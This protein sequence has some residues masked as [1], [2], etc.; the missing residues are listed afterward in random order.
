MRRASIT[1]QLLHSILLACI[2]LPRQSR[3]QNCTFC[4]SGITDPSVVL[5]GG[6]QTCADLKN[7]SS[8]LTSD[9]GELCKE[10]QGEELT[11]CPDFI[12]DLPT[13]PATGSPA[14]SSVVVRTASPSVATLASISPTLVQNTTTA[15]STLPLNTSAPSTLSPNTTAPTLSS[16]TSAPSLSPTNQ[17]ITLSP[18]L[19]PTLPPIGTAIISGFAFYD[20]NNNG[21]RE[22]AQDYGVWNI[23]S[24][25]Y[26]CDNDASPI[27]T[28]STSTQGLYQ[29]DEVFAGSYY[30]KFDY[31]SYYL[32]G[33]VWNGDPLTPSVANSA[34]PESGITN[35]FTVEDGGQFQADAAFRFNSNPTPVATPPPTSRPNLF[36]STSPPTELPTVGATTLSPTV[37][38]TTL[39]PTVTV[40]ESSSGVPSQSPTIVS[41]STTQSPTVVGINT[42]SSSPSTQVD[43]NVTSTQSPTVPLVTTTSFPTMQVDSNVTM[44]QSP[45]V[46]LVTT[47]SS[48]TQSV[49]TP[50]S[51]C[52]FCENGIP[53]ENLI[54]PDAGGGTCGEIKALTERESANSFLCSILKQPESSCCPPSSV[55]D[56]TPCSF[57]EDGIPDPDL[58][59]L[60]TKQT[61]AEM[62]SIADSEGSDTDLCSAVQQVESSCCPAS[63]VGNETVSPTSMLTTLSPSSE[64]ITPTS[65]SQP[66]S[67]FMSRVCSFCKDGMIDEGLEIPGRVGET[68]SSQKDRAESVNGLTALCRTIQQAESVC[69]PPTAAICPFCEEG[70]PVP[71]T[72][73][74]GGQSCEALQASA[75]TVPVDSDLCLEFKAVESQCCPSDASPSMTPVALTRP[76]KPSGTFNPPITTTPSPLLGPITISGIE[77]LLV[78]VESTEKVT[79]WQE[80]TAAFIVDYFRKYP[81]IVYDVN[82]NITILFQDSVDDPGSTVNRGPVRR[83]LQQTSA[84]SVIITYVQTA[85]FKSKY[86][87]S[88]VYDEGFIADEPFKKDPEGYLAMLKR[89]S[90]YYDP[91]TKVTVALP[92]P[93]PPPTPLLPSLIKSPET[94]EDTSNN[95]RR[96]IFFAIIVGVVLVAG[97]AGLLI[98]RKRRRRNRNEEGSNYA[99]NTVT[100]NIGSDEDLENRDLSNAFE[101][102]EARDAAAALTKKLSTCEVTSSGENI[103][104]IIAP[105]GKLGV[106]VSNS[107]QGGPPRVVD[108]RK[109]SPLLEK[110]QLGDEIIA[111]DDEDVQHM[112]SVEVSKMIA[113]KSKNPSRKLTILRKEERQELEPL[114]LEVEPASIERIGV[115]APKGKLGLALQNSSDGAFVSEVLEGSVLE[116]K[117]QLNDIIISVDDMNVKNLKAFHVSKILASKS[118]NSERKIVVLR[119]LNDQSPVDV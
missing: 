12:I 83:Q 108:L 62:K 11:C 96:Y 22:N 53:D 99:T 35:C 37:A 81:W 91:V 68:C 95:Y 52:T 34:N 27:A 107:P 76:P 70:I 104:Q 13:L 6:N 84:P 93:T 63:P 116:G 105:E 26:S 41:V 109:D 119:S 45:T 31:P 67:E 15:P 7:I 23:Q 57:C 86:P 115:I 44:T 16:N 110:V 38:A 5:E 56:N 71:E 47:T 94:S 17:T 66:T 75:A 112:S 58:L 98:V 113:R 8:T 48:P 30:I 111:I 10:L 43:S 100:R 77:L 117:V 2:L 89:L 42:T 114:P 78:G 65:T 64:L 74:S 33:V 61:C 51:S 69:C 102:R 54:P 73:L 60:G 21:N 49:T 46:P 50:T 3:A 118:E 19:S 25:L 39:S 80:N 90:S 9:D 79:V 88:Y 4:E 32:L 18:T 72:V 59:V 40:T 101:S 28:T 92:K 103:F 106:V 85:T 1:Y 24:T 36:V 82:V 20:S 97:V 87:E 14:P 29:F 55:I